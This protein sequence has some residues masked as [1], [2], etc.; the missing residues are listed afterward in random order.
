[1]AIGETDI[2]N[3]VEEVIDRLLTDHKYRESVA[4]NLSKV[5]KSKES[6]NVSNSNFK[7]VFETID[8]AVKAASEAFRALNAMTLEQ[9]KEIIEAIRKVGIDNARTFSDMTRKETK[10]G[11]L[12]DKIAK[13]YSSSLK[14]PGIEDLYPKAWSG[15][16]GLTI[17]EMAPWGVIA[18]VTPSTH[19][20]PT[21]INNSI[22]MISAG[23]SV[24][25][26][27]HP[28]SKRVFA[29]ALS[30]LNEAIIASGG[31]ENLITTTFEPTIESANQLFYHPGV[32]LLVVTGGPGVVK[33]AMQVPKKA[34]A[35]GPG[36][37]PVLIDETADIPQAV[38]DIIEGGA[39][40]NNL[41][42][43]AEKE[44][45]VVESVFNVFMKEMEA[46]GQVRIDKGQIET[47]TKHA[48]IHDEKS[49]EPLLNRELVGKNASFLA[50]LI[51]LKIDDSIRLLF[52]E[53][54]HN[55]PFVME[56]QM[57]PFMPI[58]RVP[59]VETGIK[60]SLKAER[61]FLHTALI[62]SRN[63]ANMHEMAKRVD[64]TIFV[65]NGPCLAGLGVGGEG[66]LSFTIATPT[67]EGV[68]TARTFTR[69]RRC[70]LKRYF[71]I[72]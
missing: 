69:L 26:A 33:A 41:L 29:F 52:G 13:H 25:F 63:I 57:M 11:R 37:A 21:L 3:I 61:G 31:P 60:L 43:I 48:F 19:P 9:R 14:T 24:V 17:V 62:H 39:F 4:V 71:R 45:F 36:N 15:D 50:E 44:I 47:L 67:G 35:A 20:V 64:T 18:A 2:R 38:S 65:K 22:S 16:N 68:T 56:E 53:T 55:H 30:K 1:M 8:Q 51:G 40:D 27:P 66:T 5:S 46:Q 42:C 28:A 59:D 72:I 23:N 12:D 70:T 10:M 49:K 7:G 54:D 34:I 32:K 58:V 6:A